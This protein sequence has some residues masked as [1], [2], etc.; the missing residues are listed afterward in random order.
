M[1]YSKNSHGS[2]VASLAAGV[3]HGVSKESELIVL[4]SSQDRRDTLWAFTRA[5]DLVAKSYPA[6]NTS[7]ILFTAAA[8]L[9]KGNESYWIR[10]KELIQQLF[11]NDAVV[12]V[13]AGNYAFWNQ[14]KRGKEKQ[15]IDTIPAAWASP[16]FPLIV[17]GAVDSTR[18]AAK[19]TQGPNG[20]TA[21]APGVDV[22][23]A[24]KDS[25]LGRRASGTSY[26]A[27]M[28]TSRYSVTIAVL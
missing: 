1:D 14:T 19:F 13:P 23:C 16:D 4:K 17:A 15:Q 24:K 20:V 3:K 10:V 25:F 7:V 28:V 5:R 27:A 2:C 8:P 12:V 26:S 11:D 21:H 18:T 6:R 9:G 22:S